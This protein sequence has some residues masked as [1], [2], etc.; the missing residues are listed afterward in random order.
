MISGTMPRHVAGLLIIWVCSGCRSFVVQQDTMVLN[1]RLMHSDDPRLVLHA[2]LPPDASPL[3]A[4]RIRRL[5]WD[6]GMPVDQL[7]V[8]LQ[9]PRYGRK[10]AP[11]LPRTVSHGRSR[12][13]RDLPPAE[14]LYMRSQWKQQIAEALSEVPF[15]C[16]G[17]AVR[18]ALSG[19]GLH[20]HYVL[21]A[22]HDSAQ[23]GHADVVKLLITNADGIIIARTRP[24]Y[25]LDY[26]LGFTEGKTWSFDFLF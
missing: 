4:V 25:S 9:S 2:K 11:R 20:I 23:M 1:A 7:T 15:D 22:R 12:L 14:Q 19:Q 26:P 3:R 5:L 16:D 17:E 24:E 21:V 6:S 18:T 8:A 10:D 13:V